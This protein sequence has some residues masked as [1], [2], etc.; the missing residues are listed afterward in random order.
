MGWVL[1]VREL[2]FCFTHVSC[3]RSF[4]LDLAKVNGLEEY[5]QQKIGYDKRKASRGV[6]DAHKSAMIE[7]EHHKEKPSRLNDTICMTILYDRCQASP[8]RRCLRGEI[9]ERT[10]SSRCHLQDMRLLVLFSRLSVI[11]C[12]SKHP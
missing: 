9:D 3:I 4:F 5:C 7:K 1:W 11:S 6:L 10:C 8:C 12:S 2:S